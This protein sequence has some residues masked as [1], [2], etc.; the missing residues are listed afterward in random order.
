[1]D[2]K[3]FWL[4]GAQVDPDH[5]GGRKHLA[6]IERPDPRPGAAVQDVLRVLGKRRHVE[7]SV[8][9]EQLEVVVQIESGAGC[10]PSDSIANR[11]R[12]RTCLVPSIPPSQ[13]GA[14]DRLVVQPAHHSPR[15]WGAYTSPRDSDGT[16]G[17]RE[18]A[19][20]ASR[21]V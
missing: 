19:S 2:A 14:I 13:R 7:V 16:V 8:E 18:S 1:V 15:R 6:D 3:P 20:R 5:F 21:P 11:T 10:Q 17:L 12:V 9:R 4:D